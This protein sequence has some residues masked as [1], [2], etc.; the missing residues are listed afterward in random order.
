MKDEL[1]CDHGICVTDERVGDSFTS[2]LTPLQD[3]LLYF[4]DPMCSWCWGITDQ[5]DR[6]KN[7][8]KDRLGFEIIL[9]GLRPGGGDAWT[10]AFREMIKGHW[11]QPAISKTGFYKSETI[12]N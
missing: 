9:G 6:L 7:E 10:P 2:A 5:L 1:N 12:R 8:F 4:G 11:Y 3:R